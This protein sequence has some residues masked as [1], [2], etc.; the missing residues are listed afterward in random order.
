VFSLVDFIDT[1][2]AKILEEKITPGCVIHQPPG[3]PHQLEAIIDGVIF[4]V[5]SQHFDPDSYRVLPGD[6]Q[7]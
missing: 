6:S 7:K 1:D 5:S 3:Q 2:S 4:E